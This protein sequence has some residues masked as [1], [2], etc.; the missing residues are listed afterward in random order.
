MIDLVVKYGWDSVTILYEN[1]DS[2]MR[3]KEIFTRTTKVITYQLIF[4]IKVFQLSTLKYPSILYCYFL[5]NISG[6]LSK[7]LQD[8]DEAID[9]Y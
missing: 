9:S 4:R 1:N 8:G 7:H 3:L 6:H 5:K 2:M